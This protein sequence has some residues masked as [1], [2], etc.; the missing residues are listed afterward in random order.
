MTSFDAGL[1]A[2]AF[3][4]ANRA[5][6]QKRL[7]NYFKK[8][9]NVLS[10]EESR[11]VKSIQDQISGSALCSSA[12][13]CPE[14]RKPFSILKLDDVELDACRACEGIW[15]DTGELQHFTGF[16]KDVPADHLHSRTSKYDCPVCGEAMKEHVFIRSH[17][18]LADKCLANHG[19]YLEKGELERAFVLSR[20]T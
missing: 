5:K 16:S 17:N 7:D 11:I 18:L 19:V 2:I 13:L 15:F 3:A 14:C 8:K 20:E 10:P 12:K 4:Q 6:R 9:K 1:V